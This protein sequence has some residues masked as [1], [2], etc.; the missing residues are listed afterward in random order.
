M[1]RLAFTTALLG[2]G[3]SRALALEGPSIGPLSTT[4][5][6]NRA[7]LLT[8]VPS[9]PAR[10]GPCDP[11]LGSIGFPLLGLSKDRPSIDESRRVHSRTLSRPSEKAATP[12]PVPP[13]W[14]LTTSTVCS[15]PTVQACFILLPI[16][17]F[18]AFRPVAKPVSPQ[19]PSCPSKRSPRRQLA[20]CHHRA[21]PLVLYS[22]LSRRRD[23]RALLHRRIRCAM[24]RFQRA[25]PGA[26][27]GLAGST[28]RSVSATPPVSE[29]AEPRGGAVSKRSSCTS[30]I[31]RPL[32]PTP[33]RLGFIAAVPT[34]SC[35]VEGCRPELDPLQR[36]A[37]GSVHPPLSPAG[38][39]RDAYR[40]ATG[41][42][43]SHRRRRRGL[44]APH[45]SDATD[46]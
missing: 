15:S 44:S 36:F 3:R 8:F 37:L 18:A 43:R 30:K 28:F 9:F 31:R 16:L 38:G 13:A 6:V 42:A 23:L 1:V 39:C 19:A 35:E 4:F 12:S 45:R 29:E 14:F 27:M 11:M 33:R 34:P 2:L 7:T 5:I 41:A 24:R 21:C 46:G 22:P 20:R 40:V 25:V 32:G 26:P 17:G 10:P